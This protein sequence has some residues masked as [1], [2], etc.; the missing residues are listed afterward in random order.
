MC[1]KGRWLGLVRDSYVPGIIK[2]AVGERDTTTEERRQDASAPI[3]TT[4]SFLFDTLSFYIP[5]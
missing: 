5:K 3:V 1:G 4:A 2:Q